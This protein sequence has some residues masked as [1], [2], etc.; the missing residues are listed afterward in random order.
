MT[1]AIEW[2]YGEY[3]KLKIAGKLKCVV[4]PIHPGTERKGIAQSV[5]ATAGKGV[6]THIALRILCMIEVITK[7][8]LNTIH[9]E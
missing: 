9:R 3:S 6:T 2:N 5:A 7:G 1:N 8:N 4:C